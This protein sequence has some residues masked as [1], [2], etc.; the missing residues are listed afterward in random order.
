MLT[1]L[2]IKGKS[3]NEKGMLTKEVN[4]TAHWRSRLESAFHLQKK[5]L[6]ILSDAFGQFL[7]EQTKTFL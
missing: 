4:Y 1:T 3:S 6:G 5:E 2:A 7:G